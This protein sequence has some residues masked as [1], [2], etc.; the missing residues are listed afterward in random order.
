[1]TYSSVIFTNLSALSLT[2]F[3]L[4]PLLPL[5]FGLRLLLDFCVRCTATLKQNQ[6]AS[7]TRASTSEAET[8][9][10]RARNAS[11][12]GRHGFGTPESSLATTPSSSL[13]TATGGAE[14]SPVFAIS[15]ASLTSA[16]SASKDAK[17]ARQFLCVDTKQLNGDTS[18]PI[19]RLPFVCPTI[20]VVPPPMNGSITL[21][22]G[23]TSN[24]ASHAAACIPARISP[25][26]CV[27]FG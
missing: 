5:P 7:K 3:P 26:P 19:A 6:A 12:I 22:P 10:K 14:N 25:N 20:N 24:I 4:P 16:E 27:H 17:D 9:A 21:S 18:T 1:M 23:N 13:D 8:L 11:R 2:M 15:A